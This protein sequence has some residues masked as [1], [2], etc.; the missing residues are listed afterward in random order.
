RAVQCLAGPGGG[1]DG[2]GRC[3]WEGDHAVPPGP[4]ARAERRGDGG[5]QQGTGAQQRPAGRGDRQRPRGKWWEGDGMKDEA[6]AVVIRDLML[7]LV[8]RTPGQL[9]YGTDTRGEIY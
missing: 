9:N 4:P 3:A 8:A 7:D 5:G 2:V 1:G 6:R